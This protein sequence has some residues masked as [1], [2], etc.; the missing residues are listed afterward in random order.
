MKKRYS[1]KSISKR[2]RQLQVRRNICMLALS[3]M[4]IVLLSVLVISF[5]T[6]AH[7]LEHPKQYKYYKSIEIT[8]GDTLWSIASENIDMNHYKNVQEYVTEIKEMNAMKS[9]HIVSGSSLIIPYYSSDL[10][11]TEY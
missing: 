1:I 5:S 10:A 3:I 9:D 7:D 11:H 2:R 6:Q 8:K 4:A